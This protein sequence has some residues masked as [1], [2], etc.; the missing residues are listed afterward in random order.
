MMVLSWWYFLGFPIWYAI[1]RSGA[2]TMNYHLE[3]EEESDGDG[4]EFQPVNSPSRQSTF[5]NEAYCDES[6]S[7]PSGRDYCVAAVFICFGFL[8]GIAGLV[9]NVYVQIYGLK[10]YQKI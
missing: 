4:A 10:V 7:C 3:H 2:S 5:E 9:T 8:A 1:A 6:L